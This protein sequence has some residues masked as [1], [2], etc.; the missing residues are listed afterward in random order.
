MDSFIKTYLSVICGQYT[1]NSWN[2][3]H[4]FSFFQDLW[5]SMSE[6]KGF[7]APESW[8][9]GVFFRFPEALNPVF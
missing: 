5:F 7:K 2:L 9:S 1:T 6:R 3:E 4:I 8:I